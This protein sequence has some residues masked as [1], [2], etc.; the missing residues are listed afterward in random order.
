VSDFTEMILPSGLI[1][2]V[3][4][5]PEPKPL[6]PALPEPPSETC[7]RCDRKRESQLHIGGFY[8]DK[9]GM[10][11][12][13]HWWTCRHDR[14]WECDECYRGKPYLNCPVCGEQGEYT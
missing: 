9:D 12:H 7:C 10:G 6:P 3:A 5:V 13:H 2:A 4:V 1:L 14:L 11:W 8:R